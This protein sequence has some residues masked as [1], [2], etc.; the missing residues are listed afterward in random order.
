MHDKPGMRVK[1]DD[2]DLRRVFGG[3]LANV[4]KQRTV[5]AMDAVKVPDC[6]DDGRA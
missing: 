6:G 1:R 5:A 2:G 4:I 3:A